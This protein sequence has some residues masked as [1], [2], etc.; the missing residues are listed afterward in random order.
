M[1]TVDFNIDILKNTVFSSLLIIISGLLINLIINIKNRWDIGVIIIGVIIFI[2]GWI[3][4]N[5]YESEDR[6]NIEMTIVYYMT[7]ITIAIIC[8]LKYIEYTKQINSTMYITGTYINTI[9]WSILAMYAIDLKLHISSNTI[10][11][12]SNSISLIT[13]L[14]LCIA[15]APSVSNN[16]NVVV[17]S[18]KIIPYVLIGYLLNNNYSIMI[19]KNSQELQELQELQEPQEPQE[20]QEQLNNKYNEVILS[21]KLNVEKVNKI[22]LLDNNAS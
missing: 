11:I 7:L 2:Y 17:N 22:S 4:L 13:S 8:A 10:S 6:T 14:I 1:F 3:K 20:T 21:I 19:E 5:N 18:L 15:T 16:R 9:L 12:D